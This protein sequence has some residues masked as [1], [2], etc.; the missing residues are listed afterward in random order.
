MAP[1]VVTDPDI[2]FGSHSRRQQLVFRLHVA[3]DTG[4]LQLPAVENFALVKHDLPVFDE[5][6]LSHVS[7]KL[8]PGWAL[9]V[10]VL[11][12]ERMPFEL[13]PVLWTLHAIAFFAEVMSGRHTVVRRYDC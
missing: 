10:R 8:L 12:G 7:D 3:T 5:F 9:D 2:I 6:V 4:S 13:L 11:S 1:V